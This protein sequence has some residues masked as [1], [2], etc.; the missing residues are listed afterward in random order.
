MTSSSRPSIH[1][2]HD[3][4][5]RGKRKYE[6]IQQLLAPAE[7]SDED[8]E[9]L[10]A[11]AAEAA[12]AAAAAAEAS[13][14]DEDENDS[15]SDKEEAYGSED[16]RAGVRGVEESKGDGGEGEGEEGAE[17]GATEGAPL[18]PNQ[19]RFVH[20]GKTYILTNDEEDDGEVSYEGE[21]EDE[22][23]IRAAEFEG[24]WAWAWA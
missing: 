7:E 22:T 19:E 17:A 15:E 4:C 14:E 2:N 10:V 8:I 12:A 20:G 1:N 21:E 11:I 16:E 3:L 18:G 9:A 13:S 6:L 5:S 24:A 23:F